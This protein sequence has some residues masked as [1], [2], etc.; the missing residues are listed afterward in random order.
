MKKENKIL[1]V[2]ILKEASRLYNEYIS[3]GKYW[4]MCSMIA[5]VIE[6]KLDRH[7]YISYS[8]ISKKYISKFN[9]EFLGVKND[10]YAPYW[11]NEEDIESRIEAFEKLI[12]YYSFSENKE[13]YIIL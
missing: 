13:K 12:D 2:D 1:I 4:G 3:N 7:N 9:K 5:S 11:W 10:Y 8:D 6:D